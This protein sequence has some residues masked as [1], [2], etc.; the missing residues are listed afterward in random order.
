VW[1]KPTVN[2]EEYDYYLRGHKL[3]YEYTQEAIGRAR[4]IWREGLQK[5]PN[6]G[7]L[8]IKI[9]WADHQFG[10]RGWASDPAA[11]LASAAAAAEVGL[12]DENL[13]PAGYRYGIWLRASSN[14]Y[15]RRDYDATVRIAK[16]IVDEFRYDTESL[17]W[18]ARLVVAAGETRLASEWIEDALRRDMNPIPSYYNVL[19]R[20]RFVQNRYD[21]AIAAFERGA[22][23]ES[24]WYLAATHQARGDSEKAREY[25]ARLTAERPGLTAH[26]IGNY[27][28]YK[29]SSVPNRILSLLA[30]SGWSEKSD[31]G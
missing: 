12:K 15:Y 31:S 20:V 2:L 5:Y 28:P 19:G 11:A 22:G 17:A 1:A 4:E 3:Y 26:A 13:P 23:A 14:L 9:G 7:L 29:D 16:Q 30:K 27:L 8:R 21:E 25:A 6:S 18:M 24:I 10:R